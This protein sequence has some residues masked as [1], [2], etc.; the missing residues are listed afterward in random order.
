[1]AGRLFGLAVATILLAAIAY[2]SRFWIFEWW[3]REGLA[4]LPALR[5]GGD[6]WR[7]WMSDLGL[8]PYDLLLWAG[9]AF[10][11]LS[12]VQSIWSRVVGGR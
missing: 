7:R 6:L 3:G 12:L 1:M 11:L 5:P 9:A 10:A 8:A 2:V 4:G